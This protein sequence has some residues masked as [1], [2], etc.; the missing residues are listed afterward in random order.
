[1]KRTLSDKS[2][3]QLSRLLVSWA[4]LMKQ[5]WSLTLALL[6]AAW[7]IACQAQQPEPWNIRGI[8]GQSEFESRADTNIVR[9]GVL[10]SN[11][12][13]IVT[14]DQA[15][16]NV[17]TGD[18][19]AEG[20]VTILDRGHI[21]R[22]TNFIYNG[23]TGDFRTTTFKTVQTPVS[24]L[25]Q[26]MTGGSNHV[27]FV[28]NA[29]ISTDDYER[30]AYTIRA[31][32]MTIVPGDYLEAR[33]LTL[34]VG[35]T[36][37]F[38][39]PYYRRSLR[40]HPNNF[41]FT[42]GD[43]SIFGPFLY[44]AY[45]WYGNGMLDGT[46]HL[47]ERERRGIA[48]GPDFLM[49]MGDWGEAAFR[50]YYAHDTDPGAD[51]I[52]APHLNNN[53]Q[54]GSLYYDVVPATNWTAKIVGNYQSD[55][56]VVRDFKEGEYQANVEPAS[57]AEVTQMSPNWVLDVMGQ[58]QIVDFF[59]TVER[60][61]DVR[62]T[63]LRQE[64]G[65]T[66]IYYESENS[67]GYFRRAFSDTNLP[68][69]ATFLSPAPN[70][71][72]YNVT[73]GST[74][75]YP[76]YEAARADTFQQFTMPE[77]FFGW[78]NVT[79][80]VG[81][82]VTYYSDVEGPTTRTNAQTRGVF[83]T[84]VDFSFKAARVFRDAESSLFEVNELRHIIEPE[85]DYGYVPAPTRSPSQL[86]QFDYQYPSLRLLPIEFPEYNAIDSIS[87]QNV[88]RLMLVNKLQTKRSDGIENLVNWAVYT[89]WNL[90][91]GTNFAFSDLYSDMDFRPRSWLTFTSSTR[92]DLADTRWREAIERLTVRPTTGLTL[93]VSYYY[94]MNNDPEFQTFAGQSL[95]G[96]NLIQADLIYRLNENWGTR[97]TEQYEAQSGV[98]QQQLYSIYHDLR[99]WTAALTFRMTQGA[100]QPSDFSVVATFSLKAFPRYHLN[101]ENDRPSLLLG[102]DTGS[103]WMDQF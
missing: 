39:L 40:Q 85:I 33:Q 74:G 29:L 87:S 94:L 16:Q 9:N 12:E 43:R 28:N 34:F 90:S 82:R 46:I 15:M 65:A 62:M 100:G 75:V 8:N 66:P 21:W 102:S 50:Y 6:L 63:G 38:Y 69:P 97:I 71:L 56:L 10:M 55:P 61:P 52:S 88:L 35:K 37:V 3:W 79:P 49:H 20:D 58:P 41:Q 89:D 77:N 103:D 2:P 51:G 22:G 23:K 76:D 25:G 19:V 70:G 72:G 83:N 80:R 68:V 99:S 32:Q 84:G 11:S 57:F 17:L 45:N 7:A 13:A 81:G 18:V 26:S 101:R 60:L 1:V 78:L 92:Y 24:V 64:V 86:P 98:M 31:R 27:F 42:P 91:R 59:E 67:L 36:P 54:K 93:A 53:R 47:D 48:T 14:A 30:P 95:P 44:S 73:H 5:P 4:L 96:H